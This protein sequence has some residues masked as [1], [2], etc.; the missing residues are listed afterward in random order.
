MLY[1]VITVINA[2]MNPLTALEDVP[3]GA[4]LEQPDRVLG[5]CEEL[6]PLLEHHGLRRPLAFWV[7]KV[8]Q[9]ARL[10]A[11]NSSSMRQ[12]L[13]H[14]RRTEIDYMNGFVV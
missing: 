11:A 3:N 13:R 9:V 4:L 10:T 14:H 8:L 5:L 2:V 1:E 6:L 7:D 12:D